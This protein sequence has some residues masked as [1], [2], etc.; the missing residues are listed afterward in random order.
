MAYVN[1]VSIGEAAA[2]EPLRYAAHPRPCIAAFPNPEEF[3]HEEIFLDSGKKH[4][5]LSFGEN[6]M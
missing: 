5:N 4:R 2:H 6:S 3:F 1:N